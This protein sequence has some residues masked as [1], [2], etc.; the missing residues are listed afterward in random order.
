MAYSSLF[1]VLKKRFRLFAVVGVIA[2]IVS[3]LFS[4]PFFIAPKYKSTAIAYPSNLITY[5]TE[6]STEQ[7]LQLLHGNDIRDS[8]IEKF[9]L[10]NHYEMDTASSGY[11]AKLFREFEGNV[12]IKKNK[13]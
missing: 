2:I 13:F 7:L 11:W 3:A 6:S 1:T 8:I 5:S 10:G 9:D 4:S 12:T